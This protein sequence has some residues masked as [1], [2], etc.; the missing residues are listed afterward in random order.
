MDE[1]RIGLCGY[2]AWMALAP[3]AWAQPIQKFSQTLDCAEFSSRMDEDAL[4][5]RFGRENVVVDKLD[6]TQ[7][8]T[9]S[10]TAVFPGDP[11]RR[12]E[13]YWQDEANRR[14]LAS[15]VVNGDSGWII[16]TPGKARSTVG[17]KASIGDLEEANER[18]FLINGFGWDYGGY[19][20]D[21]KGGK[22]GYMEGGCTISV[23]F[24]P[25]PLAKETLLDKLS[26]GKR[27]NS[28]DQAMQAVKPFLSS[29]TL[30]WPQ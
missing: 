26:G 24:S 11:A 25:D 8:E 28:S 4:V 6:N 12:L 3:A 30:D 20:A 22:L 21:W 16:R 23:R 17:L 27:L 19:V 29:I 1:M 5:K 13:I 14:G 15:I 10:G 7:G 9:V 18:P 2:L